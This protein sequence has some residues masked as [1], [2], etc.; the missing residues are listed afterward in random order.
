MNHPRR[1]C[2]AE[3]R[4]WFRSSKTRRTA[5]TLEQHL[6]IMFRSYLKHPWTSGLT[7]A[8]ILCLDRYYFGRYRAST[9]PPGSLLAGTNMVMPMRFPSPYGIRACRSSGGG[10]FESAE[11]MLGTRGNRTRIRG[12]GG[13]SKKANSFLAGPSIIVSRSPA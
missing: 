3:C 12:W 7:F 11:A 6:V 5:C 8:D 9:R 13:L 10:Q 4:H 2:G 1:P